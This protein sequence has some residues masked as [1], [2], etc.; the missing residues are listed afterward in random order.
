MTLLSFEWPIGF[1]KTTR[2]ILIS[3]FMSKECSDR[4]FCK[5]ENIGHPPILGGSNLNVK[6]VLKTKKAKNV[7]SSK[8]HFLPFR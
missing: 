1:E 5:I 7:K 2:K 6:V 8:I 3:N 4:K